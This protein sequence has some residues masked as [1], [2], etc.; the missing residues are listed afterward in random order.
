MLRIQYLGMP[1][2]GTM[3]AAFVFGIYGAHFLN[4]YL[5]RSLASSRCLSVRIGPA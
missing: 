4:L 3:E 5:V 2:K 1:P